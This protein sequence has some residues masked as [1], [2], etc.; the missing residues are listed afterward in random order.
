M[1]IDYKE[2]IKDLAHD[3]YF[4]NNKNTRR[5]S[6]EERREV[7]DSLSEDKLFVKMQK[8]LDNGNDPFENIMIFLDESV[9]EELD[10]THEM[11]LNA[12]C[13]MILSSLEQL[14]HI[15]LF[16]D[17]RN[18][19]K[20]DILDG[21]N[22]TL[23]PCAR[24]R[25]DNFY[26]ITGEPDI[27]KSINGIR[28]LIEMKTNAQHQ[29]SAKQLFNYFCYAEMENCQKKFDRYIHLIFYPKKRGL[30]SFQKSFRNLIS[31]DSNILSVSEYD[32]FINAIDAPTKRE[33][34]EKKTLELYFS[35]I[36]ILAISYE[37]LFS[38]ILEICNENSKSISKQ[39][40][41]FYNYLY[42]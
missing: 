25:Q 12:R 35:K 27:K 1:S 30:M 40:E 33:V 28:F 10:Y 22:N 32:D 4:K 17:L 19:V 7:G 20:E 13:K 8:S 2:I 38:R 9:G 21:N 16:E 18:N 31:L 15:K 36:P 26:Q 14:T 39:I 11:F 34:A 3:F 41:N 5:L 29:Y 42:N 37:E 23:Y 24:Y 6:A